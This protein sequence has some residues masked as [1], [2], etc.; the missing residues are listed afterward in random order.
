ML[1]LI[2][3]AVVFWVIW[4]IL[5]SLF[6]KKQKLPDLERDEYIIQ[7]KSGEHYI[8]IDVPEPEIENVPG[9]VV[10]FPKGGRHG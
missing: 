10:K 8:V 7:T 2:G 5:D 6:S 3:T 1:E 4:W 9:K